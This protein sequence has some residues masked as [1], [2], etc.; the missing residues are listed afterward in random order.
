MSLYS[1]YLHER[2]GF[3]CIETE[4]AFA[5]YLCAGQECYL[6]D[7]YVI[8]E[9]RNT[10]LASSI[11]DQVCEIARSKGCKYLT[12]SVSPKDPRVTENIQVLIKYGMKFIK[13]TPDLLF[14]SK[15]L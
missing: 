2:E 9:K 13:N 14:F 8:P 3:E 11:A 5:S 12:G 1:R 15:N 10:K 7:L 4:Y 6:R